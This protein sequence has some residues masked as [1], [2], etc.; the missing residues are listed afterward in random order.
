MNSPAPQ[1][2]TSFA[3]EVSQQLH[4]ITRELI[5]EAGIK[6]FCS[7]LADRLANIQED[8]KK[9]SEQPD[10]VTREPCKAVGEPH[11]LKLLDNL[12]ALCLVSFPVL[13]DL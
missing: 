11:L 7:A 10:K 5:E 2:S 8:L 12:E 13:S 4:K 1:S 6:A 3:Y 9:I